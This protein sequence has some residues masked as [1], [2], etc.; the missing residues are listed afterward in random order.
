LANALGEICDENKLKDYMKTFLP[1]HEKV[2]LEMMNKRLGL[3]ASKSGNGNL[4]LILELLGS[5]ESSKMDYNVFFYRLTHLKSFEDLSFILD[6]AVFQGPLKN[7]FES[8][9]KVCDE[10]EITFESRFEIMKKINPK[11]II[12]NY[13]LQ[14]AIEK[15]HDGDYSLVNDLLNIAQNPYAKHT[16][17][18]RYANPTPMKFSNTQLSCSS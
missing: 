6:I 5:L 12:K 3:D 18:E 8:Y 11:Y 17:F 16:D 4:H 1:Q 2:Y 10:Q 15:A 9:K 14:E 7:W 13:M